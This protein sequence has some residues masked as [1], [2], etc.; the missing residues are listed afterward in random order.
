MTPE[1]AVCVSVPARNAT[2]R[3]VAT[4]AWPTELARGTSS[5]TD[6]ARVDRFIVALY[7]RAVTRAPSTDALPAPPRLTDA[8][9]AERLRAA[10]AAAGFTEEQASERLQGP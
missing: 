6:N 1:V 8:G 3:S 4:R 7:P 9:T 2:C 5:S 10:L